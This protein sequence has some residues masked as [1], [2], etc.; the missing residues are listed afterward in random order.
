MCR[1]EAKP[2]RLS[3]HRWSCDEAV[4]RMHRRRHV[5]TRSAVPPH[6]SRVVR[7][8]VST[9]GTSPVVTAELL[10]RTG[11]SLLRLLVT[12]L[13][14]SPEVTLPLTS[15]AQSQVPPPVHCVFRRRRGDGDGAV[16]R[17]PVVPHR[18]Y[19]LDSGGRLHDS[20]P[21]CYSHLPVARCA[22]SRAGPG[23]A[24]ASV[25]SSRSATRSCAAFS[26]CPTAG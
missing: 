17:G 16:C 8:P 26:R 9:D 14:G 7:L 6:R 20:S 24:A 21:R 3:G 23:R 13:A 12:Q 5:G 4:P 11:Q 19:S 22:G 1:P 18:L 25:L 2:P 10:N 15:L